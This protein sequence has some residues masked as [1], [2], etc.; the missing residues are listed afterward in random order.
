MIINVKA[1]IMSIEGTPMKETLEKD[2][3]NVMLKTI[4][5]NAL[6]FNDQDK[7]LDGN[8]KMN[9]WKLAER[10]MAASNTES[11]ELDAKVEEVAKIKELVGKFFPTGVVGAVYSAIENC[12]G[13]E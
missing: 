1:P 13:G 8:E 5:V 7:N 10:I 6:L 4:F 11:G 12:K 3:P 9:R 2:S